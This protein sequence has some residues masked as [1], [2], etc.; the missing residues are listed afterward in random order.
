VKRNEGENSN[1]PT[2]SSSPEKRRETHEDCYG[3]QEWQINKEADAFHATEAGAN[4][5]KVC[6][7]Q[8][9][10][11]CEYKDYELDHG[12]DHSWVRMPSLPWI[13]AAKVWSI[14]PLEVWVAQTIE[15]V[16]LVLVAWGHARMV[17]VEF[18]AVGHA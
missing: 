1:N 9:Q 17:E 13:R 10:Q 4:P 15:G 5:G 2:E 18:G 3:E 14:G 6:E 11:R 12:V 16:A 7:W 8:T